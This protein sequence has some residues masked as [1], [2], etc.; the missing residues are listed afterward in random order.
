MW[1]EG[2]D[3]RKAFPHIL[4]HSIAT[5]LLDDYMDIRRVQHFLGHKGIASIQR[6]IPTSLTKDRSKRYEGIIQIASGIEDRE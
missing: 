1:K 6:F 5:H 3:Q 2:R 4:R